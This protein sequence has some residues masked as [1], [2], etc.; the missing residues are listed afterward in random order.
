MKYI[1]IDT[2]LFIEVITSNEGGN[3][4]DSVLKQLNKK[5][6]K[7]ILPE[8]IKIE[9]LTQYSY[10]KK[11]V[12][13][14]VRMNLTTKNILG[15]REELTNKEKNNR[16]KQTGETEAEKI[17]SVIESDIEKIAKKIQSHYESISNKIEIIFTHKNTNLVELT[18]HILLAG[19]RRS[20]LKKSPYT[21]TEKSTENAHTKDIDCIAFESLLAFLEGHHEEFK[22]ATLIMCVSD[23][24]YL[25]ED[26]ELHDDLKKDI[27]LKY[28]CYKTIREMMDKELHIKTNIKKSGKANKIDSALGSLSGNQGMLVEESKIVSI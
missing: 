28:K 7:I 26:G 12:A 20:V 2:N 27:N 19:M 5:N 14:S 17:D 23:K 11:G 25:S 24:D 8:V 22:D 1:F 3:I 18:D 16:K 21:K 6:V 15:I 13:D 10:W 4:L 9:I